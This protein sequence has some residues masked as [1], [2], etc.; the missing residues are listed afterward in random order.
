MATQARNKH[1][2]YTPGSPADSYE[3]F[4][5]FEE[6]LADLV[7]RLGFSGATSWGNAE[8]TAAMW[9]KRRPLYEHLA[10]TAEQF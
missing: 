10:D 7:K 9:Q 2:T 6:T 8:K 3:T 4:L 5:L 1:V